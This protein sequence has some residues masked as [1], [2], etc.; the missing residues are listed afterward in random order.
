[1]PAASADGIALTMD[2]DGGIGFDPSG[3]V[4]S[5]LRAERVGYDGI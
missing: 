1:M 2:V 5:A 4:E 3:V